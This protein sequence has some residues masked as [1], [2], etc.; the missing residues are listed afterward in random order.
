MLPKRALEQL[1]FREL[2]T[3][4]GY[5]FTEEWCVDE[6]ARLE[7]KAQYAVLVREIDQEKFAGLE[8]IVFVGP[9]YPFKT[10]GQVGNELNG[11]DGR[12]AVA[13]AVIK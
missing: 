1:T 8:S 9:D 6:I 7:G 12:I 3:A 11:I 10:L 2:L 5:E 13:V 4:S